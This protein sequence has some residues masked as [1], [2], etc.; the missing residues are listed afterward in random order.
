MSD[1][2]GTRYVL[3][4]AFK[5]MEDEGTVSVEEFEGGTLVDG[6]NWTVF[7]KKDGTVV[8]NLP[9][10]DPLYYNSNTYVF[11]DNVLGSDVIENFIFADRSLKGKLKRGLRNA[12][13]VTSIGLADIMDSFY[14]DTYNGE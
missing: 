12:G 3:R 6:G 8:L 10:N 11:I 4:Q 13:E 5:F 1:P 2:R 14:V 7:S 9:A